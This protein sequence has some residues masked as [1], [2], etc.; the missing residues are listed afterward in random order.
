MSG[1][2]ETG[3]KRASSDRLSWLLPI[4]VL[5]LGVAVW[6]IWV[7]LDHTP[8][9]FLPRPS[10]IARTLVDDRRLL[11]HHAWVTLKEVLVGCAVALI[12]GVVV[13]IAIDASRIVE[14]ALYP[15]IVASQ[16]IPIV[17]LAPLLLVWFGYGLLPKVI[18]TA[19]VAFF[20]IAVTTV[21]GLRSADRETLD[22]LRAMGADGPTRFRLVKAPSALPSL[23]SGA[24]IGVAV[25]VIGAV[26]GEYV[27]ANAGLGYLMN[28]SSG[29][30]LTDRVFACIVV[31]AAMAVLLFGAVAVLE[32]FVLPWRKYTTE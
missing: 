25:A 14:R 27:G 26:F 22:L 24:R 19:L 12:A 6:E 16:A 8:D 32:K 5:L 23:F 28:I 31:L 15:L 7:R 17:A 13:A 4:A 29:R 20:P 9:W 11:A 30:L 2:T 10:R 18:V 21:D 3:T 1:G